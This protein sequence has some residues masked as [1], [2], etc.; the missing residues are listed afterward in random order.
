MTNQQFELVPQGGLSIAEMPI[1]ISVIILDCSTSMGK[2]GQ[3]P[4]AA[5]DAHI[6]ALQGQE[7]C[8]YICGVVGFADEARIIIPLSPVEKIS[9]MGRFE[10]R[11]NTKLYDTVRMVLQK[12]MLGFQESPLE[13]L[14]NLR[15]NVAVFSDGADN[16]SED[17]ASKHLQDLTKVAIKMGFN[18]MT[19]G[20]G[21]DSQRLAADMGF[22]TDSEHAKTS[23]ATSRGVQD[24]ME[25]VTRTTTSLHKP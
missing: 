8:Q 19:F 20:I 3:T 18:L 10:A 12:L 11:G 6:V 1:T 23:A 15:I 16:R 24:S 4:G 9:G 17:G 2:Y 13:Y 5:V 22:P 25:F 14:N 21:I 7:G